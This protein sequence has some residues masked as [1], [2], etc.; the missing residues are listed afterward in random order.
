MGLFG[1]IAIFYPISNCG[2]NV[3]Y[4]GVVVVVVLVRAWWLLSWNNLEMLKSFLKT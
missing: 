3:G 1:Y 2:D 4:G